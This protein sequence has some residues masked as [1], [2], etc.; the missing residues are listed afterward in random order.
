[1]PAPDRRA[2]DKD[3][4]IDRI[5]VGRRLRR[6][7]QALGLAQNEFAERAGIAPPA[8]NQYEHGKRLI[9]PGL[10]ARLCEHYNLTL[11]WIYV[12][13]PSNLP[14]KLAAA[15]RAL[16]TLQPDDPDCDVR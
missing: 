11:D 4:G 14:Y 3:D 8:Y 12:G 6:T 16:D 5:A 7:R 9:S 10:A 15:V 1:M 2:S 13:D